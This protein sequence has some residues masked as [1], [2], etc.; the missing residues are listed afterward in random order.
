MEDS[1]RETCRAVL[2]EA[3][4]LPLKRLASQGLTVTL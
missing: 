4:F 2:T 1:S 3:T